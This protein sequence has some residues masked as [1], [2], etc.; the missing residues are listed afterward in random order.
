M[1]RTLYQRTEMKTRP[2]NMLGLLKELPAAEMEQ[3][4]LDSYAV[5]AE[6]GRQLALAR[7]VA[8]RDALIARGVPNERLF[9]A[10]PKQ[11]AARVELA[12]D[13]S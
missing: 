7:A 9:L 8:V 5:D 11:G 3:L 2:R 6:T 12:L 10:A 4:L 13:A 1:L